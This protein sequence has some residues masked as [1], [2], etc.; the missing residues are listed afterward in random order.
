MEWISQNKG[1]SLLIAAAATAGFLYWKQWRPF[2]YPILLKSD[3]PETTWKEN[4]WY[5]TDTVSYDK[6]TL[7]LEADG[8]FVVYDRDGAKT[9]DAGVHDTDPKFVGK[10]FLALQGD[11]NLVVYRGSGP[12]ENL[13]YVWGTGGH[14]TG[15]FTLQFTDDGRLAMFLEGVADPVWSV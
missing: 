8:N 11:G 10:H 9:F 14:G 2:F 6:Y 1:K 12:G 5:I 3:V 13:G 7:K 15:V 4:G